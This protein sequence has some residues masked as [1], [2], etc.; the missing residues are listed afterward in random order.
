MSAAETAARR[1]IPHPP[2]A[3]RVGVTG[4]RALSADAVPALRRA[5][6]AV[7]ASVRSALDR[8][9]A[10]K[11]VRVAYGLDGTLAPSLRLL[12]PL[13]DGADRLVAEEALRLGYRL[14][15][16]LPFSQAEYEQ[17]FEP[18]SREQFHALLA[19]TM[20][21]PPLAPP[22]V[23]ALDGAHGAHADASYEAVGRLVV[24][25][26]DLL[27]AIWN[28]E[29]AAGRGG[30]AEIVRLAALSGPPVWWIRGDSSGEPVLIDD[31]GDFRK[32]DAAL[33]GAAAEAALQRY[34]SAIILPPAARALPLGLAEY[35]QE[36]PLRDHWW[37]RTHKAVMAALSWRPRREP[38]HD[39]GITVPPSPLGNFWRRFR[40]PADTLS[41]AYR[42]RYRSS[43]ALVF[44]WAGIA[45]ICAVLALTKESW[46]APATCI[47]LAAL[48][49]IAALV[50]GNL[51][52]RWHERWMDYRL[53]AE[54]CRK[55]EALALFGWC[56]P[57]AQVTRVLGE[58]ASKQTR[59]EPPDGAPRGAWVRW[60]FD[61]LVRAAPL[62]TGA[63]VGKQLEAAR[64]RVRATLIAGQAA[65][66]R[67]RRDDNERAARVLAVVA[68][69]SFALTLVLVMIKLALLRRDPEAAHMLGMVTAILPA[70]SATSVGF[71]AYAELETIAHESERMERVMT[72]AAARI[73]ALRLDEPLASQDLAA[74]VL[75]LANE[76]LRDVEGWEHLF[77]IKVIEAP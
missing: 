48:L 35:L 64:Q 51:H 41:V 70:V 4:T 21:D 66:H 30:T 73:G 15:A 22:R 77:R 33:R 69:G 68:W 12:S 7:L 60:Y 67:I 37:W 75:V 34:L 8:A 13:A 23:L 11:L 32:P 40:D 46:R 50:W 19:E 55:Q 63:L 56:L 71:R 49:F 76:M 26:C 17:D 58:G 45:L 14:E 24:R 1:F 25:N 18:T 44:G 16:A 65:Y 39:K 5:V 72:D 36:Q 10:D 54:L 57:I 3:V 29:P 61:A 74:E 28:G 20:T 31:I 42:D 62:P 47:E 27:I 53:L 43:Y 59:P 38:P 9:A 2:L 52:G 6:A